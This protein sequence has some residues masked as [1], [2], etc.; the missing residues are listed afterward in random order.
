VQEEATI[1]IYIRV[2]T[3]SKEPQRA[4][5]VRFCHKKIEIYLVLAIRNHGNHGTLFFFN[6]QECQ[7]QI[8]NLFDSILGFGLVKDF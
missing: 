8:Q 6:T 5:N 1:E 2:K 4:S 7:N 3:H